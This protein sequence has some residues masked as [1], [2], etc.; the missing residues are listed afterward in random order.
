MDADAKAMTRLTTFLLGLLIGVSAWCAD[1]YL[2][3]SVAGEIEH[4]Y[5]VI[6]ECGIYGVVVVYRDGSSAMYTAENPAPGE[7]IIALPQEK[8]TALVVPCPFP[9]SRIQGG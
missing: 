2:R 7:Q 9:A 6:S 8:R 4:A 5:G 1:N 3:A